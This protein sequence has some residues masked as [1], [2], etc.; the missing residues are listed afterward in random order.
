[1]ASLFIYLFYR[2][3]RTVINELFIKIFSFQKYYTLKNAVNLHLPLN[4]QLI[5]SLPEGLWVFA[6]SLI[7][8]DFYIEI[9][10]WKLRGVFIPL[11][12]ALSLELLQLFNFT[13]G[14]FDLIDIAFAII[15]W[16]IAFFVKIDHG[17]RNIFKPFTMNGFACML[18]YAIVFLAHVWK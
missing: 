13:N 10:K 3:E 17:E 15:F 1:M 6:A 14:R 2:T 7:S 4:K 16:F 8:K 11:A 18:C 9:N 5:Y 12:F